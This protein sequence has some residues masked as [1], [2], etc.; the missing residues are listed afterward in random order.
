MEPFNSRV[1]NVLNLTLALVA[2]VLTKQMGIY[3]CV[4]V[5]C[6]YLLLKLIK[7]EIIDSIGDI[8]II[9]GIP[10]G[11]NVIWS[12][13]TSFYV[14]RGQF[15][16][17]RFSVDELVALVKGQGQEYQYITIENMLD[18]I[19]NYPL[20]SK[21]VNLSYLAIVVL[22]IAITVIFYHC[23][24]ERFVA[25]EF[26]T[27]NLGFIA[28][29]IGYIFVMLI[30]YFFGFS[31]AE[32][33]GL[34]CYER[35][36]SA[37]LF[38]MVMIGCIYIVDIV[39][40]KV[41][42]SEGVLLAA[43]T[44]G[45]LVGG[46]SQDIFLENITPGILC[47]NITNVFIGD[48][49]IINDHTEEDDKI[50]IICQGDIGG[51]RNII[52]YLSAPRRFNMSYFTVDEGDRDEMLNIIK[53]YDYFFLSNVDEKFINSYGDLFEGEFVENQQLYRINKEDGVCVFERIY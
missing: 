6:G 35:Y 47:D 23:N 32:S 38:P 4:L 13:V 1:L 36:M 28:G 53:E 24:K 14:E 3:F 30:L 10:L 45:I 33:M 19:V 7:G 17:S 34:I 41:R 8:L 52:A 51:D 29:A 5:I 26:W 43:I 9:G 48:A 18:A 39:I 11:C 46:V 31:E 21:P 27:L 15:D 40:K 44:C 25:K 42:L 22:F 12:K 37:M 49:T 16:S 2:L 20:M 50:Y